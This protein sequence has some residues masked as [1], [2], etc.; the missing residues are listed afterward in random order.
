MDDTDLSDTTKRIDEELGKS[1]LVKF[2]WKAREG[3]HEKDD[4]HDE[5]LQPIAKTEPNDAVT[6]LLHRLAMLR[7]K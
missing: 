3:Q 5:V 2:L 4:H 6:C 1:E 7:R